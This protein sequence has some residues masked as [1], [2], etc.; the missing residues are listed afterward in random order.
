MTKDQSLLKQ[1]RNFVLGCP[2]VPVAQSGV[3]APGRVILGT[4]QY[5]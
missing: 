4:T 1:W 3:G 5:T 2:W